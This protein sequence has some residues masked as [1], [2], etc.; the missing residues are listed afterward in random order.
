MSALPNFPPFSVHENATDIRWKKW[1]LRLDN[2]ILAMGIKNDKARQRALLLHYAGEEVNEIFETLPNTGDDYDTAVARLTEYFAPKKN[3]EFEVYKFR[4]AKQEPGETI[5]TFH[6]KLRQ[7]SLT[8]EFNNNDKEV[9]SQIIQG[10]SSTRLRRRALRD[11]VNLEDLLKLARSLELSDK[12]ASEIEKT[13]K[14]AEEVNSMRKRRNVPKFLERKRDTRDRTDTPSKEKCFNC[15]GQFPHLKGPCPA[16]GKTCNACHKIGHFASVCRSKSKSMNRKPKSVR[17]LDACNSDS[18]SE[19]C[20]YLFG[21]DQI[22]SITKRQPRIKVEING[23]PV[24]VLVDTGSSINVVDE[25][26]FKKLENKVKLRKA[27]TRVFAY[28]SKTTLDIMGKF[29]ATIENKNKI[30]IADVYVVKGNSGSLL[31]Y[32]TCVQLQIVQKI[33]SL[34]DDKI[35]IL[36]QKYPKVFNGIGKLKHKQVKLHVDESVKPVSQPH[37][38][39]PFHVR[40]QVEKE[41]EKLEK[42]DIIEKVNGP[43]P[44]VSPI[45]VAPKPKKPGEIRLCVDMR[46]A[47]TAIQR[48]RHVTPTIDDMILDLN[49][50]KVFSKLDLNAGYHQLE[51]HPDSRNITTFSTHVGLRRYKRLSF[52]ISSAAEVFQ[53][54]LSTAL[55]GLQGVRNISDDI[56]V[57]GQTCEEHDKNLEAVFKRL[58]EKHLTLNKEKCEFNK[59]QIEFYGYVFSSEGISADPRKVDAIKNSE[60]PSNASEVRSFLGMTNYVGRFIPNYSTITAPLRELTKQNVKFEWQPNQQKA[61]DMLKRELTSDKVMAYF[62]P[63]KETTMIVDASPVGLGALLTQEGKVISYGSRALNDV[64]TRYSQTEREALAVVWGCEHFHLYLFGQDFKVISDHKPLEAI[65]NNPHSKPPARIERWRLK[66]QPYHFGL[67]YRPGKTNAA[68]YM[69]RH[70]SKSTKINSLS[71]IAE[72]YVNYVTENAV[73]KTLTLAEIGNETQKDPILQ[74]VIEAI[75]SEKKIPESKDLDKTIETFRRRQ[76]ELTLHRDGNHSVLLIENRLVI[77]RSIQQTV[78]KLAH[79][80]HQGIVRT[81]QLLREKVWFVNIDKQV[82]EFCKGCVPCQAS[83]PGQKY[84]PLKMSPLPNRPWSEVSMDFCGPFPSGSYLMVVVDD[85]SRYPVVEIL[86]KLTAKAVI[87]KLDNVFALFGIP[88]VVKTDNGPPF[89][90]LLFKEFAKHLGF[91]HRKITPLWPQ[92]NGE[93]ER[94]MKTIGKA[95]RAAHAE[96]RSWKQELYCFLRN[97]RA[98]PHATTS[99]TPAELLLGRKLKTRIPEIIPSSK[100]TEIS[101][102]DQKEKEKMKRYADIRRGALDHKLQPG[103]KVLVKQQ[104]QTNYQLHT[105]P[106]RT[107]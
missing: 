19:S 68:D 40:K 74:R 87:P 51:L 13:D 102:K 27:D 92:A 41:L 94:F 62:D 29:Q 93:A 26:T 82:E 60:I 101:R 5:D 18:D 103:D 16:K 104:K 81:K 106:S 42:L 86:T 25:C 10:C 65:F 24:S 43:T 85:Y 28:G 64:E 80:G 37:R 107:K 20:E 2:L 9:K 32:D 3:T 73:P 88:D 57:F 71:D 78:I 39:I 22:N 36:C 100:N 23:I 98:T 1:K 70:P 91:Q 47:N 48:E 52:G 77:P 53:N 34:S 17:Q 49:G 46:K 83:V 56:I 63:S 72:E 61:F 66:L 8:C 50:S 33:A 90:G 38:R 59:T 76:N 6:T 97:Y 96:Q 12:Q 11:D 35:E 44:W 67:Q 89:N 31:G 15:G 79:E 69:S 55:E 75:I 105:V 54:S 30:E 21:L 99:T 45:V 4:Q 84:T 14:S 95:I 7:L 58:E